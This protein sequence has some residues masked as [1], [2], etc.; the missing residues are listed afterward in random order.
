MTGPALGPRFT[1]GEVEARWQAFWDEH[2]YARPPAASK[3]P[4]F[5]L[6]LPPPNVTGV[7]TLG[8][9]LG[10]TVMDTLV[11]WHRMRGDPALWVPGIDH[12]GLATQVEVRRR[13]QKQGIR[14]EA[15]PVDERIQRIEEWKR[16]HETRILA[17]LRAAGFSLDWSR[18]RYTM[19]PLA[20]RATREVF[21]ELY[22]AGLIYR[23]ERMVNWDPRLHTAL[24]DLEVVHG[25]EKAE[26]LYVEYRWADGAPGGLVLATVRPETIFGDVAVAVHPD[27]ERHRAA[28]GR[29]VIVPLTDRAVPVVTD[30]AIDPTFGNGA[31]K[32]TPRHD[33]VDL[34]IFRR[35]PELSMP[36]ELFD[37]DA[38]LAG[39]W[40]PVEFRGMDRE[41]G[42][43]R[44]TEA[45]ERAQL[46]VKREPY[47]HSVGRSE[48]SDAVVEPRISTQWFVK[49]PALAGPAVDA[50]RSGAIRFHP[51]RWEPSFFRWM[52]E[53]QDWCISRQVS[54]GHRIPVYYCAGC[55]TETAAVDAPVRCPKCASP[56]LTPD[57]DVLDTWFT[58]WLWPFAILGW[59]ETTEALHRFYPTSVLVTGR[60]IMFF[61]VARM[62]MAGFRFMGRPPFRDVYFTGM[63]R[64]ETGRRMSKHLGNSPDPLEVIRE[65][66]ADA[67]RFALLFPNP[68]DQDGPFG[69]GT[70]DGARNFLTKLWNLVRFATQQLP[71]GEPAP[72]SAPPMAELAAIDRWVLSRWSATAHEVNG[73]LESFEFTR[74][75]TALYTFLWHDVADWY[76]EMAKE[77][78]LGRNGEPA[79]RASRATLLFVL[80]RSLRLIHPMIPHVTEELWHA[81]PHDGESLA[82]APWPS[83]DEAA[84]DPEIELALDSVFDTVRSFRNLRAENHLPPTELVA[85]AMLPSSPE[86]ARVLR[87]ESATIIR[88]ARLQALTVLTAGSPRPSNSASRVI[89]AGE[90]FLSVSTTLEGTE[91][92]ERE[93]AKLT[94]LLEKTRAKLNDPT[95]RA[96]APAAVVQESE[97]KARELAER[98]GRL[99]QHLADARTGEASS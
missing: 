36:P 31:L 79:A 92:L 62:M 10:G 33:P 21:V 97:E 17:Q 20:V 60:D 1:P 18:Y 4:P 91:T 63:L 96:R 24:S 59:P 13:L 86:V 53:L 85:G 58:S 81:L 70:L 29:K 67:L 99:S 77:S 89:P 32:L 98:I 80:E 9:M 72:R 2:G 41:S 51:A 23:G 16:E 3:N 26:L 52:E 54:W 37:E 61:W 27:D 71:P 68:V 49:T 34:E 43:A 14:L 48:R 76:V 78:L 42:R 11:R 74:A 5:T 15:L 28:V 7:L 90:V 88:L 82:I 94:D 30:A 22:Q 47:A 40:V 93:R 56:H 83:P 64:D 84:S 87:G 50:V 46:L 55:G 65:R 35:H 39:D 19:D 38:R 69:T 6:I 75:A 95:F 73:A 45:L 25:Q 12:A 66:G 57:P 44:V 8:H